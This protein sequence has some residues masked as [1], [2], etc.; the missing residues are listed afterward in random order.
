MSTVSHWP[1]FPVETADAGTK[2]RWEGGILTIDL[3]EIADLAASES[4]V[5]SVSAAIVR[6]AEP[7]R[8]IHVTDVVLP[9]AEVED[10]GLTF[11]GVLNRSNAPPAYQHRLGGL[12]VTG[13]VDF[14]ASHDFS[15]LGEAPDVDS[16]LDMAGPGAEITPVAQ[17]I[18]LVLTFELN[19]K[20]SLADA[21]LGFRCGCL[22]AARYLAETTI[23]AKPTSRI[24]TA[25]SDAP[26]GRVLAD[27]P[28]IAA[29]I[30]IGAEGLLLDTYLYGRS[31]NGSDP[32]YITAAELMGGAVTNGAYDYAGLRNTTFG[33]QSGGVVRELLAAD[34]VRLNFRGVVLTRAY[35]QTTEEKR[36]SSRM[37]AELIKEL[38]ADGVVITTFQSGNSQTELMYS[39]QECERLGI[40]T[41]AVIAESDGGLTDEVAEADCLISSG[42]ED[43]MIAAWKPK[44][45]LG[46]ETLEQ[47]RSAFD[48]GPIPVCCYLGAAS[49]LGDTRLQ[50][51]TW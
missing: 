3:E 27:L 43:E 1:L 32:L 15:G 45:V 38:G 21:D 26:S 22:R 28:R 29:L 14:S 31:L 41:T 33:Y 12:A 39:I 42:N 19:G 11:P 20:S 25:K 23:A 37:A 9:A 18:H 51:V 50:A 16:L 5:S 2:T 44:T 35:L 36:R 40:A 7:V 47:G 17:L 46:G 10:P 6:P 8:L 34:G 30:H 49:Q 4:G 24:A 13:L 48:S